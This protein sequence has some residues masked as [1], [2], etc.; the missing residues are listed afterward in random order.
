LPHLFCYKLQQ[1]GC[2]VSRFD[3]SAVRVAAIGALLIGLGLTLSACGRK[4]PLDPPPAA[5]TGPQPSSL[6]TDTQ[7]RDIAPPGEK[8][9]LP[10]DILLD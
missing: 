3:H 2:S 9:R 10:I 7:G 5:L 4:G 6:Q 8:K 1:K